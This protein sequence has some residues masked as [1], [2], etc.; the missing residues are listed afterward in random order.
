MSPCY[1]CHDWCISIFKIILYKYIRFYIMILLSFDFSKISFWYVEYCSFLIKINWSASW[2]YF[3]LV[4][5]REWDGAGD[6][7]RASHMKIK[8][9]KILYYLFDLVLYSQLFMI[10]YQP[11][12][13]QYPYLY[14]CTFTNTNVSIFFY[15]P[16]PLPQWLL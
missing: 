16:Y 7:T 3:F 6:Q 10:E 14:Q 1:L 9:F 4:I 5:F 11:N 2:G 12:N 8:C 13:V 15:S